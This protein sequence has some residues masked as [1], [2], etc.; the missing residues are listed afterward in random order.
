MT[1]KCGKGASDS[2]VHVH[3]FIESPLLATL[4]PGIEVVL[5]LDEVS[6]VL[7]VDNV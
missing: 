7:S 1:C 5:R 2:A 3:H 6:L 4:T